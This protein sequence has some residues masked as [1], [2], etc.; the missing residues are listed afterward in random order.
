MVGSNDDV[1]FE[2]VGKGWPLISRL[3]ADPAYMSRYRVHLRFALGGLYERD[4]LAARIREW[5][6]PM[7]RA[8]QRYRR[9]TLSIAHSWPV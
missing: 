7:T 3:L 9:L 5:H 1:L 6:D 4:R 8:A 2:N